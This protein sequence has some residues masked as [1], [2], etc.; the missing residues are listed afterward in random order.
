MTVS[1]R[2]FFKGILAGAA[3]ISPVAQ[4][5]KVLAEEP[6]LPPGMFRMSGQTLAAY[7]IPITK[8]IEENSVKDI[9][10]IEDREFLRCL[11]RASR[12]V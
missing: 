3:L 8:I 9:Q 11:E 4:V 6:P 10:E 2:D 5:A 1:R 12:A 7:E